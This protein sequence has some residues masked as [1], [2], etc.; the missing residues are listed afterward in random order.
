MLTA[1]Q[2][3]NII[4]TKGHERPEALNR[5]G[6]DIHLTEMRSACGNAIGVVSPMRQSRTVR[7]KCAIFI[8]L[9]IMDA[10][11]T[12]AM[13]RDTSVHALRGGCAAAAE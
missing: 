9:A 6:M 7:R 8:A 5:V 11:S 10:G 2:V 1:D 13:T 3:I 12:R 4:H